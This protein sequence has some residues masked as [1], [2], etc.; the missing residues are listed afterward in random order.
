MPRSSSDSPSHDSVFELIGD[1]SGQL[2]TTAIHTGHDLRSAVADAMVL[3]EQTRFREE[4]PFTDR[5][6]ERMPARV[7][8]HRSRFEIDLN[9][10]REEAVYRTP[11]DCWDLE[12]WRENPLDE[13]LVEGSLELYDDFYSKLA[14]R[15]DEV[16]ARGPFVLYDV[17][18]YNHRRDG[19]EG[20]PSPQEDN[21]DVNVGTGS[22]DR[23]RFGP[24]VDAFMTS[25]G[26]VETSTGQM[27]VRE[28][29]RFKGANLARWTHERYPGVGC[30]LA[31]EFKKT[32][33]DEWTGVPDE[34]RLDELAAA[35][36]K[37]AAPVLE[38]LKQIR[39]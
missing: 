39:G 17:H 30:A 8:V 10:S 14:A 21:P 33:M 1:W 36:E 5:I 29:V 12:V 25:L 6:G 34:A 31:L 4:D 37:T 7:I 23:D 16:A 22:L 38:A 27:D 3:D 19:A 28:N 20:D 18:S 11:E 24:V 32:F 35:L 15:L 26:Q 13:K 9:R 2:V